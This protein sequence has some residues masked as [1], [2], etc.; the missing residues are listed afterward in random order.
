MSTSSKLQAGFQKLLDKAG[1]Q[2]CIRRFQVSIG[3]IWDDDV[4]LTSGA[5]FETWTSGIVLPIKGSFGSSESILMEQGKLIDGDIKLFVSGSVTF[6]D[7]G[8]YVIRVGIGSP[9]VI[10]YKP[11]P[12]GVKKQ[13]VA[14]INIYRKAYFRRLTGTGSYLGEE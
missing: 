5:N 7:M 6:T 14:G 9:P 10:E 3:S 11:I 12:L 1:K 2:M 13:E 8:S 4:T